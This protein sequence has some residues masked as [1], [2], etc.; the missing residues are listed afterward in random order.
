MFLVD[1]NVVSEARKA[2]RAKPGVRAF[3]TRA[4]AESVWLPVQVIG[5]LRAGVERIRRRGDAPQAARL[6]GWLDR[7]VDQYAD[8]VL[9]FDTDCAQAWGA[10]MGASP[11]HAVDK[12][13]AAIALLHDLT[14]VSRNESDFTDTGARVMNPFT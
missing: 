13:I 14:V 3:W 8:R 11:Q 5:E 4:A 1:T 10:L 12:Q 9:A 7:V 2:D 6:Q